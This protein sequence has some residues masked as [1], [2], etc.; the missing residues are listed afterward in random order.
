[1]RKQLL[2]VAL[3]IS[4]SA[5]AHAQAQLMPKDETL[6]GAGEEDVQGWNPS[7]AG[8]ATVNL[9]SNSNVVGQVEGFSTLFGIGIA[10]G[11]DY[12]ADRHLFRGTLS[13]TESFART[14]VVDELVKTNDVVQLDGLYNYFMRKKLGMFGRLSVKASAFAA[15]DIRGV[16]TTWVEKT[17]PPTPLVTAGF[18]Q[19]L[20]DP[21]SPLTFAES[22]GLFAE[23][24]DGEKLTLSLRAG[25]GGRQTFAEDVLLI[26]DDKATPEIEL[27]RL[28]DV[29]QLGFEGFAGV[30]GKLKGGKLAYRGGLALLFPL[31]NN[32]K[33]D[34]G[35]GAL[36]RI[37]FESSVTFTVFDWMSL[38]Y[39]LHVTRDPQLFPEGNELTQVQNSLL[40]T[41]T[42]TLVEKAKKKK[43]APPSAA[44]QELAAARARAEAAEKAK[45]EADA[46]I[47]ELEE[48]L[49]ACSSGCPPAPA[50]APEPAPAPAPEPAPAPAPA[51]APVP[52]P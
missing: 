24:L 33:F 49:G 20:A 28:A 6:K 14:P 16:E 46:K 9:V 3:V 32:D 34:R 19:R 30:T 40:L 15:E 39:S 2:A 52:A 36:T 8:T 50:P 44:E 10:G 1:M 7:L 27:L 18:R 43:E 4:S 42:Y 45:L 31:V 38:V 5:T 37:G 41:F 51:P 12:T 22:A 23:P 25:F 17:D 48:K 47:R 26:D 11:A 13:I 29:H 35:A 21:L